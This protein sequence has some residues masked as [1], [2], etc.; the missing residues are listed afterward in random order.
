MSKLNY[1]LSQTSFWCPIG[2]NN[3]KFNSKFD[4][5]TKDKQPHSIII[6][7]NKYIIRLKFFIIIKPIQSSKS[8]ALGI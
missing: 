7:Y 2:K 8:E 1:V 3:G 6:Y 4:S 5:K